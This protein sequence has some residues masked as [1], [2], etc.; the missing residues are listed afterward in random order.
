MSLRQAHRD[1]PDDRLAAAAR[2]M[3]MD[4]VRPERARDLYRT[5]P[6]MVSNMRE[7]P[8]PQPLPPTWTSGPG[9]KLLLDLG[10]WDCRFPVGDA[11]DA[12]QLFCGDR[13]QRGKP[14]CRTCEARVLGTVVNPKVLH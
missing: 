5:R 8:K 12:A 2:S 4:D 11:V 10:N 3:G 13:S 1:R 6:V 14:Y 7:P 9:A